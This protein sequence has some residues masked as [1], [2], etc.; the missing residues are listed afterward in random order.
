MGEKERGEEKEKVMKK[1]IRQNLR[2][3]ILNWLDKIFYNH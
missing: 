3:H 2:G 1:I